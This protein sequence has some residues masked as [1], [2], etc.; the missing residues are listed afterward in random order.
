M[1]E[2]KV[3]K[4]KLSNGQVIRFFDKD[5][6]HY[7]EK[8]NRLLVGDAY[9]D[10]LIINN[11][12]TILEIDDIPADQYTEVVVRDGMKRL[13]VRPKNE[14]L[15]DIGGYSAKMDNEAKTL[16]IKLGKQ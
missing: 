9:I 13:R 3:T 5:A 6:L 7:D 16:K 4:L 12:L 2:R 14:F 11:N 15:A 8:V 1:A 10:N